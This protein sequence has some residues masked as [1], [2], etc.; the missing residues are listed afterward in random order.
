MQYNGFAEERKQDINKNFEY[1]ISLLDR[2]SEYCS[3]VENLT[4]NLLAHHDEGVRLVSYMHNVAARLQD[5]KRCI[6]EATQ[7]VRKIS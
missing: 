2:A 7:E 3:D 5:C 1:I 4:D 6:Q